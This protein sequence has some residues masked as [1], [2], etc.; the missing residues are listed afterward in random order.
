MSP[1]APVENAVCEIYEG[2]VEDCQ[3]ARTQWNERRAEIAE[4]GLRGKGID[5]ELRCLQARFARSYALVRNH[6]RDCDGCEFARR[7]D[8]GSGH[9]G[10]GHGIPEFG[11]S[12]F[13]GAHSA[14][15]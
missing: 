14:C 3:I 4:V 15:I 7:V 6:V 5:N 13:S 11:M 10:N 1:L 9:A 12:V 2:L 8:H